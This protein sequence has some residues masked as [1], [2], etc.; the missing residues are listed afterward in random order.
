MGPWEV[1]AG[2][3]AV[4]DDV[5]ARLVTLEGAREVRADHGAVVRAHGALSERPDVLLVPGGGWF[6]RTRRTVRGRR[7]A[8]GT[9][10]GRSPSAMPR[11]PSSRRSARA[12][13]CSRT[14]GSC[15]AAARPRTGVPSTTCAAS[16]A[17]RSSTRGS[18][19]TVTWSRRGDR[20]AGST[21]RSRSSDASAER[22]WRRLPRPRST[23]SA[24]PPSSDRRPAPAR[25]AR[26]RGGAGR[27]TPARGAPAHGRG[28]TGR[29]G[30]RRGR[31]AASSTKPA[32]VVVNVELDS[33]IAAS[34]TFA[35]P[36]G[37]RVAVRVERR[38][39]LPPHPAGLDVRAPGASNSTRSPRRVRRNPR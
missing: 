24:R 6:D 17:S 31:R 15:G 30:T 5:T 2:V 18:S 13:S 8:A 36:G 32:I 9:S 21:S 4:R 34:S 14:R 35:V 12:R 1:L 22:P 23:T 11:A 19:T 33:R 26:R 39:L 7:P 10:R 37:V 28:G 27:A 25:V 3:A 16:R 38:L 29:G 20:S